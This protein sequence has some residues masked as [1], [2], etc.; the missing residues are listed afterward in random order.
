R[1]SVGLFRAI[2]AG[3][4]DR[5][6]PLLDALELPNDGGFNPDCFVLEGEGEEARIRLTD[7]AYRTLHAS[8]EAAPVISRE[9]QGKT[10]HCLGMQARGVNGKSVFDELYDYVLF[11]ADNTYFL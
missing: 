7:D 4:V 8:N 1:N 10:I 3:N 11:V 2:A 5:S 9:L 6:I